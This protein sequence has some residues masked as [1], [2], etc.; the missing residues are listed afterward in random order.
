LGCTASVAVVPRT[1]SASLFVIRS[2]RPVIEK[3]PHTDV[4]S[5]IFEPR[6][7]FLCPVRSPLL[8]LLFVIL[9]LVRSAFGYFDFGNNALS[10]AP[11]TPFS[12]TPTFEFSQ[13]LLHGLRCRIVF[14]GYLLSMGLVLLS[15]STTPLRQ[16]MSPASSAFQLLTS[17]Y[18]H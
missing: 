10:P 1:G 12:S 16:V 3:L 8:G 9:P 5:L 15:E 11:S 14:E 13:V 7:A 6:C 4:S 2:A 17:C 18:Q